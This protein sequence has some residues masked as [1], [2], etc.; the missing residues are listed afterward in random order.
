[1]TY[2]PV[3][4]VKLDKSLNDQFISENNF[5]TIKSLIPLIYSLDLKVVAEKIEDNEKKD[6]LIRGNCDYIQ[7][8]IFA[9]PLTI[10]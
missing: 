8:Y 7:G 2:I 3:D 6:K 5:G 4:K 9:K 10:E 1:M